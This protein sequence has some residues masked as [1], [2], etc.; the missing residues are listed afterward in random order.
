M[1]V[2]TRLEGAHLA[3]NLLGDPSERDLF[4]Y[5]PPSYEGSN[6]RYPTAYLLHAYGETMPSSPELPNRGYS[7][8][9][10][11]RRVTGRSPSVG[12]YGRRSAPSVR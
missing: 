10:R 7:P 3:G 11:R 9:W 1:I 2:H 6:R 5:L 12:T 8:A 4:V